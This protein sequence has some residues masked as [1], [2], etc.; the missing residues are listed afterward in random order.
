MDFNIKKNQKQQRVG[1]PPARG[2]TDRQV[3]NLAKGHNATMTNQFQKRRQTELL[4]N[5]SD[6]SARALNAGS[7][8]GSIG[9]FNSTS[10][11]S[12]LQSKL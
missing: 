2:A 8:L 11:V 7:G 12:D 9:P 3:G 5:M 10:R 6:G 1:M 4:K